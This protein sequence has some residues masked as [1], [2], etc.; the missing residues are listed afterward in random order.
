MLVTENDTSKRSDIFRPAPGGLL[1]NRFIPVRHL[2]LGQNLRGRNTEKIRRTK[3][4]GTDFLRLL[5]PNTQSRGMST[6]GGSSGAKRYKGYMFEEAHCE[7]IPKTQPSVW[8][9]ENCVFI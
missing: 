4:E 7:T 2:D 1:T 6:R 5:G 8:I 9:L 3:P